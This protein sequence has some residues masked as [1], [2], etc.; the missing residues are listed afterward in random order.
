MNPTRIR[1]ALLPLLLAGLLYAWPGS[2]GAIWPLVA[3]SVLAGSV[4]EY[5]QAH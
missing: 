4:L 5:R 1:T 2:A 3:L